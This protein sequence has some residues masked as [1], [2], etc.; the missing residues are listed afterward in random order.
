[1]KH[2]GSFPY[3]MDAP[4]RHNGQRQTNEQ[5]DGR[6]DAFLRLSVRLCLKWSLT[7]KY[8][9]TEVV[10]FSVVAFRHWHL[11]R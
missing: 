8:I 1:M 3:R 9:V 4:D 7:L 11:T 5:T 10:L 6:R 2:R